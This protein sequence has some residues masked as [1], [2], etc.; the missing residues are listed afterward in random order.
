[1]Y[2]PSLRHTFGN[3]VD[4]R[5]L[6]GYSIVEAARDLFRWRDA[7]SFF[8][9][10]VDIETLASFLPALQAAHPTDVL[11]SLYGIATDGSTLEIDY[12][13]SPSV[14]FQEFVAHCTL[15]SKML[16][17]IVRPWAPSRDSIRAGAV[18]YRT[19]E[20]GGEP[21]DLP[22]WICQVDNLSFGHRR[23][24][25]YGRK[26][27]DVLV[28][29]PRRGQYNASKGSAAAPIFGTPQ[30]DGSVTF[31]GSM[32]VSGFA[33]GQVDEIGFRAAGGTVHA[34]WIELCGW[35]KGDKTVPHH[36]WRTLC[37]DRGPGGI[38]APSWYHIACQYWLE[39]GEGDDIT[40]DVIQ[41]DQHPSTALEYMQR[42][43]SVIWDRALFKT[44]AVNADGADDVDDADD[45]CEPLFGLAPR[46]ARAGDHI[47]V[48]HGLS[49]P[50]AL[51]RVDARRWRVVGECFV[52]GM[53][54]G[55]A[56]LVEAFRER[57][58]EFTL[59]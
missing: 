53:M 30:P 39:Y 32:V 45:G 54:D 23:K 20:N 4:L 50:V 56:M 10:T 11:Y 46:Q 49:V 33:M 58:R 43:Q 6:E 24:N 1:V 31:D 52:Y 17:I 29:H 15:R 40:Y 13:K 34:E 26:N 12:T 59:T 19:Q 25:I 37:A 3:L 35:R 38:P 7:N 41:R 5:A 27:G 44:T 9:S 21:H 36:L 2:L 18:A 42:V 55:E 14:A 51:R 8:L 16:D 22:S 48:L 57:T 28:G 47:C